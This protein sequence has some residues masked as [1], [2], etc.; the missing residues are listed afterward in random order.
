[1]E[2]EFVLLLVFII[3]SVG[4]VAISLYVFPTPGL[5]EE[6]DCRDF[7]VVSSSKVFPLI[8]ALHALS[9]FVGNVLGNML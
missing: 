7:D 8:K 2:A 5:K 3:I 6:E 9:G 4:A 1:M